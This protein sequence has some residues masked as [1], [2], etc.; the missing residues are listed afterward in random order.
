MDDGSQADSPPADVN[1]TPC[2]VV[3][4]NVTRN[5]QSPEPI[6]RAGIWR[7]R[8]QYW[9]FSSSPSYDRSGFT[10]ADESF[11]REVQP[12]AAPVQN[13]PAPLQLAPAQRQRDQRAF[14]DLLLYHPWREDAHTNAQLY[15]LLRCLHAAKF[16][17]GVQNHFFVAKTWL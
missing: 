9:Q 15:Q 1:W 13:A 6:S 8:A 12:Y 10:Q 17:H 4:Q 5:N 7:I 2:C 3:P 14:L 16:D 11:L